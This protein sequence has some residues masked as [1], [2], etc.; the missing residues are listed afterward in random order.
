VAL[1]TASLVL[2]VTIVAPPPPSEPPGGYWSF[3]EQHERAGEPQDGEDELTLGSVLLSLGL[4][5]LGAAGV[6]IW[7]G[8]QPQYCPPDD[9][10]VD[11]GPLRIYGWVGV[12]EGALML[13]TGIVYLGIGAH[14]RRRHEA[15][16]RGE[17]LSLR[18]GN[19]HAHLSARPWLMLRPATRAAQNATRPAVQTFT[20]P[21]FEGAGLRLQLRF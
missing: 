3:G 13:G 19:S 4:L 6:T 2:A 12:G 21:V 7:M 1:L 5:R 9:P 10:S 14:H 15:W 8:D 20:A 16:R 11:C 18:L 17:P